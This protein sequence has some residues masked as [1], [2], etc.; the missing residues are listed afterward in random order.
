MTVE[1]RGNQV[2][3]LVES[4]LK[5][6]ALASAKRI[7][8]DAKRFAPKGKIKRE[9]YGKG[10]PWS[11]REPGTLGDS[12]KTYLSKYGDGYTVFAG[13]YYA[14]YA[15]FVELGTPG[16]SIPKRPFLRR[17]MKKEDRRFKRELKK[18]LGA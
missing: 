18:A 11:R 16:R 5:E 3:S 17:A 6:E 7:E 10:Q 9:A 15:R 14:Y 4:V 13:D 1:W 2:L 8:K 12:I